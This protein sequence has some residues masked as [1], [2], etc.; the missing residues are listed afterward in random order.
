MEET[1]KTKLLT[2]LQIKVL[3]DILDRLD[4]IAD[5]YERLFN[6]SEKFFSDMRQQFIQEII[7]EAVDLELEKTKRGRVAKYHG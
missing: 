1:A 5:R 4:L 6:R 2:T 7:K 3:E